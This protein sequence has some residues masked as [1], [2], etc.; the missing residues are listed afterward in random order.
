[1]ELFWEDIEGHQRVKDV[2]ARSVATGRTHHALLFA[3]PKGVGKHAL[4]YALSAVLYCTNRTDDVRAC[5]RCPS[6]RKMRQG[7]HPDIIQI[8]PEGK[9]LK[10]I[11]I[12]QIRA[13]QKKSATAPYEA[14]QHVVIIDDAHM[15]NEEA[16][17]A[18]LKTLEEPSA[19][20]RLVLV[21]DN[22]HLLLDTIL[23]R[24]Q[25]V[26]FGALD[27]T[28]VTSI[29]ERLVRQSETMENTPGP[30]LLE[31]AA[32]FGEGSPGIAFHVLQSGMLHERENL[33]RDI[34]ALEANRPLG[35]LTL[36]EQL[37]K[38]NPMLAEH[39]DIL[40]VF[41]RDIML[42][43]IHPDRSGLINQDLIRYIEQLDEVM[44][45]DDTLHVIDLIRQARQ[46]Y[47]RNVNP[48]LILEDMLEQLSHYTSAST[49]KR[50]MARPT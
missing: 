39:F 49:P 37:A 36:A 17:N 8:V 12:D 41:M 48:Q 47:H 6:C 21:T 25:L 33:L 31:T 16:A 10:R 44:S 14:P 26:R 3:G 40:Q 35:I 34:L 38:Q 20:L 29:L 45:L 13:M 1:M 24:C 28:Q 15:M 18:L 4:A 30:Q 27:P 11:K 5:D 46:R 42:Y 19:H 7:I 23:S 9:K 50:V 22:V 43:K 32:G 2:L